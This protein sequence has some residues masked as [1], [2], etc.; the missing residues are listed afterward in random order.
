MPQIRFPLGL[1]PDP[2]GGAYSAPPDPLA[3]F[4]GPTSKGGKGRQMGGEEMGEVGNGRESGERDKGKGKGR[5]G[6]QEGT[7][8]SSCLHPL[9]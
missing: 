4:K 2:G 5:K 6:R 9:I 3:G 8:H 7:T 1:R